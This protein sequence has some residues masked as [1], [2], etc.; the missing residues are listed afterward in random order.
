MSKSHLTHRFIILARN[1]QADYFFILHSRYVGELDPL[2]PLCDLSVFVFH[3]I[4]NVGELDH[5]V[6]NKT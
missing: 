2:D 4:T 3:S 1:W 5:T 6:K